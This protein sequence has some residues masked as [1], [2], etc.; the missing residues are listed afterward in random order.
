MTYLVTLAS[1][2]AYAPAFAR[3][4]SDSPKVTMLEPIKIEVKLRPATMRSRPWKTVKA[5]TPA[6]QRGESS[7]KKNLASFSLES[8]E[9]SILL[10]R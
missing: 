4:S 6:P 9:D 1:T 8:F 5:T 7:A 2:L 10:K 3:A